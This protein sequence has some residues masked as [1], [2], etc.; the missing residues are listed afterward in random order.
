MSFPMGLAKFDLMSWEGATFR[1]ETPPRSP[2]FLFSVYFPEKPID[3]C[4]SLIKPF[5]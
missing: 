1:Y 3:A 2:C 4:L 5:M